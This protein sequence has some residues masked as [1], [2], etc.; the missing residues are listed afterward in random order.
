MGI[1][2]PH[3][4]S[5]AIVGA[6]ALAGQFAGMLVGRVHLGE[7]QLPT[8]KDH[9]DKPMAPPAIPLTMEGLL[10]S[11]VVGGGALVAWKSASGAGR[12]GGAIAAAGAAAGMGYAQFV[13]DKSLSVESANNRLFAVLNSG[14]ANGVIAPG[15]G[16]AI[17]LTELAEDLNTDGRWYLTKPE[18]GVYVEKTYSDGNGRVSYDN[19]QEMRGDEYWAFR[20]SDR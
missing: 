4:K 15:S 16:D 9:W 3:A 2:I 17:G 13:K 14:S 10:A 6:G 20:F 7:R 5:V 1:P 8:P 18:L 19:L 11:S 12:I